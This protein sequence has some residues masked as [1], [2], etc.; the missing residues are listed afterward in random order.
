[1]VTKFLSDAHVG[2]STSRSSEQHQSASTHGMTILRRITSGRIVL[3]LPLDIAQQAAGAEAEQVRRAATTA[4]VLLSS[5]P[6]TRVDCLAVRMP[7]AGF[8]AHSHSGLLGIFANGARHH[9][10]HWQRGVVGSLPVEVLMK[11][12][13]AIMATTAG[14]RHVAQRRRSPVAKDDLHVSRA[15]G[16]FERRD[17]VVQRLPSPPK[18]WARVMT[19]S[20]SWAPASTERRISATRSASGD[21]P[22]GKPVDTAATRMP[23]PSRARSAVS[24]NDVIHANGGDFHVELFD[25][26][27]RPDPVAAG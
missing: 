4:R 24:T 3:Q 21:S 25:P 23:L 8:E 9:Q 27:L 19:T 26:K 16:F 6:A 11:S 10:A 1:M 20:I 2:R 17:F 15:A 13:P 7:P 18:T 5:G 12:A 22:A 14:A